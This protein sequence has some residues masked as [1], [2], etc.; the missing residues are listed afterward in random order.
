[1]VRDVIRLFDEQT[2]LLNRASAQK[3][4]F[5]GFCSGPFK[6]GRDGWMMP[7]AA[8]N[9][10]NPGEPDAFRLTRRLRPRL[11][12]GFEADNA[13]STANHWSYPPND[14]QSWSEKL[15]HTVVTASIDGAPG[16]VLH[17][18]IAY[19]LLR[20]RPVE[21]I[22]DFDGHEVAARLSFSVDGGAPRDLNIL[23]Q[24]EIDGVHFDGRPSGTYR[25]VT[26]DS[27]G[28][29]TVEERRQE[30]YTIFSPKY[31]DEFADFPE[32]E[33]NRED[34]AR[35]FADGDPFRR[36]DMDAC[37][38]AFLYW[39]CTAWLTFDLRVDGNCVVDEFLKP[40]HLREFYGPWECCGGWRRIRFDSD[41]EPEDDC[42]SDSEEMARYQ[43]DPMYQTSIN[44]GHVSPHMAAA[45]V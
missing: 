10:A 31:W 12:S 34:L 45:L 5:R 36:C 30:G 20:P 42:D 29:E 27:D 25:V 3:T 6:V 1:V 19:K 23:H 26:A 11:C 37:L 24:G 28:A 2:Q 44:K 39:A 22:S 13:G 14:E 9:S 38:S 32:M 7:K 40:A 41:S 21:N 33:R 16:V 43:Y 35:R 4:R 15:L 18:D 17:L 8:A